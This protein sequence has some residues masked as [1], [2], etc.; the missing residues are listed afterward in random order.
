[1]AIYN[2]CDS[3]DSRSE[4]RQCLRPGMEAIFAPQP[5]TT[6]TIVAPNKTS[7]RMTGTNSSRKQ[8]LRTHVY[9]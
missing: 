8:G 2:L 1:M 7:D 3:L 5:G 6:E 4:E 9:Y